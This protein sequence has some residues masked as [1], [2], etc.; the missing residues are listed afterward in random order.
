MR[1]P[2]TL[3]AYIGKQFLVSITVAIMIV[4]GII[5][6]VEL[7]ELFRRTSSKENIPVG[8]VMQM[9]LLKLP[10]TAE[11]ILPFAVLI[12][13]M[14]SLSRLTR[15]QELV[16]ARA[17]GIS[18][19]QFLLPALGIAMLVGVVMVGVFNPIASSMVSRYERL[20][21]RYITNQP[22]VL[23]VS[24]SGLWL[25]QVDKAGATLNA[26]PIREYIL[27]AK[28]IDQNDMT[29]HDV[30]LFLYG[31]RDVFV[32]RIDAK[33]AR[34]VAGVE[35]NMW[36]IRDMM[37]SVAGLP[38]AKREAYD[39][40]T[41]LSIRQIQDSFASPDTLSFWELG[42]F[43]ST[44]EKAGFSA[45]RHKLHWYSLLATPLMLAAMVLLAAVFS[46]RLPRRGKTGLLI[47]AGIV[48]GF[49]VHFVTNLVYALGLSGSLPVLLAALTPTIV[50]LMLA[51]AL[52]LHFEDG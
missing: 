17:S 44:L 38:V 18:V 45:I 40:P 31:D 36:Q 33:K 27:Q 1:L 30:V 41:D 13:A 32:G 23:S 11:K 25:R 8:I 10:H 2:L 20:E 3:S 48:S 5:G 51:A 43:I 49:I 34:L 42:S 21:G 16:V 35:H 47:V 24:A 7:M 15:A 29:M 6:L 28:R 37:L 26:K 4:I 52:L 14:V 19:W 50:A 39:L 22:S 46:L 12:G 9:A